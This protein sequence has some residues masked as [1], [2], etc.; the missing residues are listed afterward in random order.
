MQE[1]MNIDYSNTEENDNE[2][3]INY[4]HDFE[5]N[6]SSIDIDNIINGYTGYMRIARLLFLAEHCPPLKI[7]AYKAALTF[8][9]E[10]FNTSLYTLIHKHLN[11]T[12]TKQYV[13]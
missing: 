6:N 1:A 3:D 13:A 12:I 4:M 2:N 8:V 5:I 10:T 9:Q 7:D 11:D